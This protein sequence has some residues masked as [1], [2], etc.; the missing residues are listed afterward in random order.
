M[1]YPELRMKGRSQA[2]EWKDGG[3]L[4][5]SGCF[6]IPRAISLEMAVCGSHGNLSRKLG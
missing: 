3:T 5:V 6:A 4:K 1:T 2:E